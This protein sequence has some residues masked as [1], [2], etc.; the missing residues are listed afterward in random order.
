MDFWTFL[1]KLIWPGLLISILITYH[2]QIREFFGT[3]K[4]WKEISAPGMGLKRKIQAS[5]TEPP[6]PT[7]KKASESK[8]DLSLEAKEV[9]STLWKHQKEY[10]PDNPRKGRWSFVV[11]LGGPNFADYLMGVGETFK[12]GLV[13]IDP[14]S[15]QCLLTDAGIYYCEHNEDKLLSE[16]DY[17]R[18]KK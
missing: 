16:W 1:S 17:D 4:E 10:Y 13:T 6:E 12:K 3:L 2:E 15:G 7:G 18:W 11:A 9:I 8:E 14:K 5:I